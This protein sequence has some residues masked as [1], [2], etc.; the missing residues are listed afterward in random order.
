MNNNS[1]N[2][3]GPQVLIRALQL[4]DILV[5]SPGLTVIELCEKLGV[6]R[7]TIYTLLKPLQEY[8]YVEKDPKSG[9][10]RLGY[11]FYE[12]GKYYR[13]YFSFTPVLEVHAKMLS[14]NTGLQSNAGVFVHP[15]NVLIIVT[16]D[17]TN[18]FRTQP[19]ALMPVYCSSCGKAILAWKPESELESIL[20]SIHFFR[21]TPATILS[22]DQ[23]RQDLSLTRERGYSVESGE[24]F[25]STA[26]IGAPLR[27]ET[28]EVVAAL[29]VYG[30]RDYI[31]SHEKELAEAVINEARETERDMQ[32]SFF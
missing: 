28:G 15:A 14:R 31:L 3:N 5:G 29:S 16:A 11:K 8:S 30:S 6:T 18:E 21:Y 23:L 9:K 20:S 22:A 32:W 13:H 1:T 24:F 12:Y 10:Y 27:K 2:K 17:M 4:F 25:S 26:C 19:E 7:P